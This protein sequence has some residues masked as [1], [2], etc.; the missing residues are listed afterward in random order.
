MQYSEIITI[1]NEIK[2]ELKNIE[3]ATSTYTLT[4]SDMEGMIR[5]FKSTDMKNL[6]RIFGTDWDSHHISKNQSFLY[7]SFSTIH[8]DPKAI[9][10]HLGD[11][12]NFNIVQI[13]SAEDFFQYSTVLSYK[14]LLLCTVV[15]EFKDLEYCINISGS[16]VR[17]LLCEKL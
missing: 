10:Y 16:F 13:Y 17:K 14:H 3:N 12:V 8:L 7:E 6:L 1:C 5:D 2:D 4:Y 11:D 9:H 15:S